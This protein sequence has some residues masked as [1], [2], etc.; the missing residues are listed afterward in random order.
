MKEKQQLY[1]KSRGA[2]DQ[3]L[4]NNPTSLKANLCWD[5]VL[6]IKSISFCHSIM[7]L[8]KSVFLNTF[9]FH[10][11]EIPQSSSVTFSFLEGGRNG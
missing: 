2:Q 11:A 6:K 8:F 1:E 9:K 3:I 7:S 4:A 10:C 5:W